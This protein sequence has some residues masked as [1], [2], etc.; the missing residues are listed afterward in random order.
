MSE[1]IFN[2]DTF[3]NMQVTGALDTQRIP[4]P[5]HDY[6]AVID[7]IKPRKAKDSAILDVLWLVDGGTMT[8]E[9]KT[10]QQ[11]TGLPKNVARQSIFLDLTPEGGLDLSKGKNVPLGQLRDALGQNDP[12]KSWSPGMLKGQVAKIT[13]KHRMADDG[14]G[15][16]YTDVRGVT[17]TE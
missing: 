15:Q 16:M 9:G 13:I 5:A 12:S 11:V 6:V 10:V 17:K 2:P 1:T 8:P 4:I 7:D 3:L 14:S